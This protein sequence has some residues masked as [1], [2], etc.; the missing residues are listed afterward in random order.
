MSAYG[1]QRSRMNRA[2]ATDYT[3]ASCGSLVEIVFDDS[4]NRFPTGERRARFATYD[5]SEE[6]R[7][8]LGREECEQSRRNESAGECGLQ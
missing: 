5:W 4:D 3:F 6:G 2:I 8:Q 1:A 7:V